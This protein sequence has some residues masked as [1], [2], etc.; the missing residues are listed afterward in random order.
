MYS[1]G[2]YFGYVP[3]Y[4]IPGRYDMDIG[5]FSKN[6]LLSKRELCFLSVLL[7]WIQKN[8]EK[9]ARN[10]QTSKVDVISEEFDTWC[11][12]DWRVAGFSVSFSERKQVNKGKWIWG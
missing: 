5:N 9:W 6:I 12:R 2:D 4:D 10:P 3:I 8:L 7:R 11:D 1:Y